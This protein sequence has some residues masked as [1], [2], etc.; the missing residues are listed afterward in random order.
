MTTPAVNLSVIGNGTCKRTFYY[1]P[2]VPSHSTVACLGTD[3]LSDVR[4]ESVSVPLVDG[5]RTCAAFYHFG[6]RVAIHGGSAKFRG[7][8]YYPGSG[9]SGDILGLSVV[10]RAKEVSSNTVN[11]SLV[12]TYSKIKAQDISLSITAAEIGKAIRMVDSRLYLI[13]RQ[14]IA[15]RRNSLKAFLKAR[16]TQRYN[17][18]RESWCE[19]PRIWL[20]L[21]Y[22]WK[23]LMADIQGAINRVARIS[24]EKPPLVYAKAS[25][26]D[27]FVERWPMQT[28]GWSVGGNAYLDVTFE[29]R[30]NSYLFFKVASTKMVDSG[31]LGLIEPASLVWEVLPWSFVVDWALP[32]GPWLNALTAAYGLSFVGGG[33]SKKVRSVATTV[34]PPVATGGYKLDSFTPPRVSAEMAFFRRVCYASAPVPGLYVKNPFSTGHALNGLALLAVAF[35]PDPKWSLK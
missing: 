6:H 26:T 20:E 9:V 21:Q 11:A 14:V 22:G 8:G 35:T 23:P 5:Y 34:V 16:A 24:A 32:I 28:G 3:W 29:E 33:T 13:A 27:K 12:K 30:A 17:L 10:P 25:H 1:S 18:P 15:F 31:Q 19:I 2:G 7:N 4:P